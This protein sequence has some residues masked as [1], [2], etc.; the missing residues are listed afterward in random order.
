MDERIKRILNE[1]VQA[2]DDASYNFEGDRYHVVISRAYYAVF[3]CIQ[4]LLQKERILVKTHRG[5]HK[6][7]HQLYVKTKIF[8]LEFGEIVAKLADLRNASDYDYSITISLV[9]R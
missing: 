9:M 6:K 4:A 3:Y 7:F 5:T 2:I 8:D 1:A